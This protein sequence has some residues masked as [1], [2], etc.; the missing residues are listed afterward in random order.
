MKNSVCFLCCILGLLI[1]L[2]TVCDAGLFLKNDIEFELFVNDRFHVFNDFF[3]S[4]VKKFNQDRELHIFYV[5]PSITALL[6]P[7]IQGVLE[8]ESEFIYDFDEKNSEDDFEV[9]NAYIQ[10]VI[11]GWNWVYFLAG[12]QALKTG[13]GLIYDDES[14]SFRIKADLER[15]FEWPLKL[16]MF[17]AEVEND[18]P[19]VHTELKYNFSFFES[20]IFSYGWFRDTDDGIAN[21]FND[22]RD[23]NIYKSRGEMHWFGISVKKFLGNVFLRTTFIY[24]KGS[25]RLKEA[26][27]DSSTMR[28]RGYLLDVNFDYN[29]SNNFSG[30]LFFYVSSGD[31]RPEKGTLRSFISID[32]YVDKTNIFFNGGID[33]QF[34]SDNVGLNGIQL[35]GVITPGLKLDCRAGKNTY[36]KLTL[37]YL[38]THQGT[39]GNGHIYG[40]EADLLFYYNI[41]NNL[42]LFAE[43]NVFEP[44]DY[45]KRLAR[46]R[47]HTSTEMIIGVSY[48]FNN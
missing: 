33:S 15:G 22:H 10:A 9:R 7:H 4:G 30:S 40:W 46:H 8:L 45:F 25:V 35:S 17:A 16:Q 3:D 19:Y 43:F 38:L 42:Q 32:P 23:E 26:G 34:A 13:G 44:G 37:A 18:C 2:E 36:L 28:M 14:P 11:P 48:Y 31:D 12:R 21:I 1:A 24:E 27:V 41:K 29:F 5:N 6:A 39:G 20:V 47:D